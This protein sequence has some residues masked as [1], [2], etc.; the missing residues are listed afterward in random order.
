MV[1]T[2]GEDVLHTAGTPYVN[3]VSTFDGGH[4]RGRCPSHS[5][6][7]ICERCQHV[8]DGGHTRGGRPSHSRNFICERCQHV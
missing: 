8:F 6:N 7:S 2:L 1:V 4:T 5:R 3:G